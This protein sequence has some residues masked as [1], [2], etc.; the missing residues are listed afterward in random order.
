[1]TRLIEALDGLPADELVVQHGH[2]PPP[3]R[4]RESVTFMAFG[5]ML[6]R[7][8]AADVVITHAGVGSVLCATR[9]GHTPLVV[10][11]LRRLG[12]HVDDHQVEL[13]EALEQAGSVVA[14]WDLG[15][16]AAAVAS[17]PPRRPPAEQGERR[18]HAAVREQLAPAQAVVAEATGAVEAGGQ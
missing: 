9:A 2:A 18:L 10:P 1:M 13:A 7:F 15:E 12:E 14:V 16:L 17:A 4:A 8:E 11:R 3:R 6:E 5:D